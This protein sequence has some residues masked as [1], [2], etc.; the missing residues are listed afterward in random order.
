MLDM[1]DQDVFMNPFGAFFEV[2]VPFYI[3]PGHVEKGEKGKHFSYLD[4]F[5]Y[6]VLQHWSLGPRCPDN[7]G[8]TVYKCTSNSCF[9]T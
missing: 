9:T 3:I 4:Y 7:R 6:P 1:T 2:Q 5:T 8:C